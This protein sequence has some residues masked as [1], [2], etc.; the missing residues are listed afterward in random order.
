MKIRNNHIKYFKSCLKETPTF[1]KMLHSLRTADEISQTELA[2][3]AKVSKGLICDIEKGRRDAS[4]ELVISLA[5]IMGYPPESFISILLE[6]QLRRA[7]LNF[8][9]TLEKAA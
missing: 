1:G 9:V 3:K 7:H 2:K 4:I 5:K 8:T 6:E